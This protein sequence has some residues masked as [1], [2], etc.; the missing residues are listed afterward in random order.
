MRTN[1]GKCGK[2]LYFNLLEIYYVSETHSKIRLALIE[3]ESCT[4]MKSLYFASIVVKRNNFELTNNLFISD[5]LL[6]TTV[7]A[8]ICKCEHTGNKQIVFTWI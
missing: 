8:Y 1:H 5:A 4:I 6:I 7:N 3:L 2:L